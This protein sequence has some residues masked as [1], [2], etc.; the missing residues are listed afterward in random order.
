MAATDVSS[1]A[2]ISQDQFLTLLLAGLQQQDPMQ[3]MDSQTFLTQL[4]QLAS[5]EGMQ[6]LN[7]NF[8]SMLKLQ[9]LTEGAG[10]I[11]KTVQYTSGQNQAS[12]KVNSLAV[13]NGNIVLNVGATQVT[14]DQVTAVISN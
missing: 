12:G 5:V 2:G 14:L 7:A 3:P 8:S 1:L 11:G 9:Q 13:Q 10:L 4:S 6:T